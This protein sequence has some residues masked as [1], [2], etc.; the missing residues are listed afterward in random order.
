MNSIPRGQT[1]ERRAYMKAYNE[2]HPRSDRRAYSAE[3]HATHKEEEAAYR[4]ANQDKLKAEKKEWYKKNRTQVLK[5][6]KSNATQNR[7]KILAYQSDYYLNNADKVKANVAAY[8]QANPEK[9]S[10]LENRRRARKFSNGGSHTL[11][12]LQEKFSRLGNVCYYCK[13]AKPLT[14]DHDIPL[15]RGGTDNIEN[16]LPAC[17]SCNSK[18][19]AKTADEFIGRTNHQRIGGVGGDQEKGG[20]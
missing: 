19:N 2:S 12:E 9:K 11:E 10:H 18:K 5:R 8:R 1:P 15:S 7:E 17:R 3:Y 16:V 4:T 6:V 13:Q 14:V 20:R